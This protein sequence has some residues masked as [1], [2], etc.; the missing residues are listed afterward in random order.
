MSNLLDNTSRVFV[1][2]VL[3]GCNTA[4][5]VSVL[6]LFRQKQL[7]FVYSIH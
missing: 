7:Q 1:I 3:W 4:V 5:S 6:H 2:E